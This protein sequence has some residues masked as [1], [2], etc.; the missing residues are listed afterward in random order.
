MSNPSH[1]GDKYRKAECRKAVTATLAAGEQHDLS[2][3]EMLSAAF[4][5]GWKAKGRAAKLRE[6]W[7]DDNF[8]DRS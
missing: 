7:K 8:K 4:N 2:L 3:A 5:S 1:G 6:S